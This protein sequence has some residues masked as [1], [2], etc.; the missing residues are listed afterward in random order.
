MTLPAF[1]AD[2]GVAVA[3]GAGVVVGVDIASVAVGFSVGT[4]TV[5]VAVGWTIEGACVSAVTC[6]AGV[7]CVHPADM[8]AARIT[9]IASAVIRET[10]F[11]P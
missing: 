11:I 3:E 8:A 10:D 4:A 9:R 2:A 1:V 6:D 5:A 7:F